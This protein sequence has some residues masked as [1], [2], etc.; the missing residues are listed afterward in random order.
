MH[1]AVIEVWLDS[2]SLAKAMYEALKPEVDSM[3][4]T[5]YKASIELSKLSVKLTIEAHSLSK[6]RAALN[7]YLRWITSIKGATSFL[8]G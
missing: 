1:R 7:S 3:P 2:P 8:V 4:R 5:H 6:L